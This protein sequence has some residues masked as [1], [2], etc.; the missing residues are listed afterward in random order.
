MKNFN[1]ESI[2]KELKYLKTDSNEHFMSPFH[3]YKRGTLLVVPYSLFAFC[4]S[5]S[6][7]NKLPAILPLPQPGGFCWSLLLTPFITGSN[8]YLKLDLIS[9][10]KW[11]DLTFAL[12]LCFLAQNFWM[13][14]SLLS[15][16]FW[17]K[18]FCVISLIKTTNEFS[19]PGSYLFQ[20]I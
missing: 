6:R 19:T 9:I 10:S 14:I 4:F 20:R 2:K 11:L 18:S 16:S 8:F 3:H 13:V 12:Y 7:P 1:R 5:A 17:T 15:P